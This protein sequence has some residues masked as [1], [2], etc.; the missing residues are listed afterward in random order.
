MQSSFD[1]K[2]TPAH[3]AIIMDGNGRW[4]RAQNLPRTAGHRA[5]IDALRE[6]VRAAPDQGIRTLSVYA[7]SADNWQRPPAEVAALM[8]LFSEY[9]DS[10]TEDLVR[11]GVRLSVI[12]R[13]DRLAPDLVGEIERSEAATQFGDALHL[14]VAIDYS[15]RQAILAAA[16]ALG[17]DATEADLTRELTSDAGPVD[18]LIRTSGEQR[19]S[20][21]MLWEC[22]YAELYFT[23]KHWPDFTESDLT[24][25]LNAY[26]ARSRTFG[27]L[28]AEAA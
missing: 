15:G 12:G 23:Q 8:R 13:R 14:R 28:P 25:A 24:E 5:G 21:F 22:A 10:E 18:L 3:V 2:Q 27:A 19:L 26:R 6:I 1:N 9:L 20:D 7:F 11:D 17:P 16:R 4:A